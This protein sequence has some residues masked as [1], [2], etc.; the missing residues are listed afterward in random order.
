MLNNE[1]RLVGICVSEFIECGTE[2]YPKKKLIIEVEKKNKKAAV[3]M[4]VIIYNKNALIDTT[5]S[6]NGK[7][8]VVDGYIDFYKEYTS[9]ICQ[10]IYVVSATAPIFDL[11]IEEP[12]APEDDDKV[13]GL[14]DDELPF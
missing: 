3:Q 4:P 8:V 9:L 11:P 14:T 7:T 10:D 12:K 6:L 1:F 13:V 2:A 5:K